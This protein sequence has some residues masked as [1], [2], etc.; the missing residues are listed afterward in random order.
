[1]TPPSLT[2][3]QLIAAANPYLPTDN[4]STPDY[5]TPIIIEQQLDVGGW[6]FKGVPHHIEKAIRIPYTYYDDHGVQ[7]RDYLLIGYEGGGAY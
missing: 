2:L 3:E 6:S 1:M 7:V 5:E 4:S